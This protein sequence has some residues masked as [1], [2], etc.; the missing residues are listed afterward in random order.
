M[1][2]DI[3]GQDMGF[4]DARTWNSWAV[5]GFADAVHFVSLDTYQQH[6]Y[7][8]HGY[9]AHLYSTEDTLLVASASDLLCFDKEANLHWITEN[10][11][12]DGVVIKGVEHNMIFGEGEWNPPGG[13]HPFTLWLHSGRTTTER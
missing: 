13:W 10:L 12:I 6:S 2:L 4:A 1:R 11:G 3:F 8:L 7:S 5:I 9:F